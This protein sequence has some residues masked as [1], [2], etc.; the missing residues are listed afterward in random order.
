MIWIKGNGKVYNSRPGPCFKHALVASKFTSMKSR[1]LY[2]KYFSVIVVDIDYRLSNIVLHDQLL[3]GSK[4]ILVESDI[5]SVFGI[6]FWYFCNVT[7]FNCI[8]CIKVNYAIY[9]CAFNFSHFLLNL[10]TTGSLSVSF[11]TNYS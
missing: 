2:P 6:Y 5:K 4:S 9:L 11:G 7:D 8:I 1:E 3:D 10:W